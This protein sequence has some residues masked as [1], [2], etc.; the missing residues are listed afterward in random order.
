MDEKKS[1][2]SDARQREMGRRIERLEEENKMLRRMEALEE[3]NKKLKGS[4]WK[5]LFENRNIFPCSRQLNQGDLAT[6]EEE[7]MDTTLLDK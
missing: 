2:A 5:S 1:E 4:V 6:Q 3:E 7:I